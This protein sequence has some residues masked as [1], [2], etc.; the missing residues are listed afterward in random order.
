M[1]F[2]LVPRCYLKAEGA[3]HAKAWRLR[4]LAEGQLQSSGRWRSRSAIDEATGHAGRAGGR[5]PGPPRWAHSRIEDRRTTV[6][7]LI[8]RACSSSSTMT[9]AGWRMGDR[10]SGSMVPP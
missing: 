3:F 8:L 1:Y 5:H 2:L 10:H 4:Y 6:L 7:S 9:S